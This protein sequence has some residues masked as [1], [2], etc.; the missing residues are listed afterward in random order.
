MKIKK[1]LETHIK[2]KQTLLGVGPMSK[3]CVDASI[4]ISDNYNI[5]LM[6]IASR[7]QVDSKEHKG[8]Y[9]ENWNTETFSKYVKKK[10]KR[11]KIILCRD[12]GG[13]WQN[14]IELNRNLTLRKAMTSCKLSYMKDIDND[15]KIIHIDPSISP[16]KNKAVSKKNILSRAFE[17]M[18]FCHDYARKKGKKILIEVGTEEQ[19]GSTNSFEEIE[20]F[21]NQISKFCEKIKI[22]KPSFVVI[23]SGT[24][25]LETENIGSFESP[26]RIKKEIPPEI[27]I[28]KALELCEKYGVWMK[29]HNAD[30]LSD[31]SLKWHPRIGIHAVNVAP[32]F[33]V[34]E[35]RA[36][37]DIMRKYKLKKELN[38]FLELSLKS[39]KWKK[40]MKPNSRSSDEE[41]AI[42][43]GHYVFSL[44]SV[45]EIKKRIDH[46]LKKKKLDLN[47][48]LK[49]IIKTRIKRYL[50]N[51]RM[52][53]SE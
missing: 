24:K 31:E 5:P 44:P 17:L 3:N 21:L 4:E 14:N 23:Q 45:I 34:Y 52:I 47:L 29:E 19:S 37:I 53:N 41:K 48:Q 46:S 32:E 42:I 26:I 49:N 16:Q 39:N 50:T 10:T 51:F 36:L 28:F 15:F 27:Q 6:L 33:G 2:K 8:G 30:Y 43:C 18:E 7:R 22:D 1:L 25:V 40:W 11:N 20:D 12:H 9:V 13:P 38:Q 35:S